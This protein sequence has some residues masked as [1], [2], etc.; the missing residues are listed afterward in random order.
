MLQRERHELRVPGAGEHRVT[1]LRHALERG[2]EIHFLER[3][4]AED[5]RVDLPG[6]RENRGTIDL[7]VPESG[8]EIRRAGSRD[9]KA[10]RRAAR[11]LRVRTRGERRSA[12]CRMFTNW[13]APA[14]SC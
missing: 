11:E 2:A 1:E 4:R 3:T 8:E 6:E 14:S 5:L 13:S 7:G 9:R 10:G 12:S